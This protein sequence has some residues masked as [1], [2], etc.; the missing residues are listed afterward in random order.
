MADGANDR[1][2]AGV[3]FMKARTETMTELGGC[4][5]THAEAFF[6]PTKLPTKM[7]SKLI[8]TPESVPINLPNNQRSVYIRELLVNEG[9]IA[10]DSGSSFPAEDQAELDDLI[11]AEVNASAERARRLLAELQQ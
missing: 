4:A 5:R 11:E 2:G 1:G 10:R 8:G 3:N 6:P 9:R 7:L